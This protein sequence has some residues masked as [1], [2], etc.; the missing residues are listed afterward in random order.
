MEE[1]NDQWCLIRGNFAG[2]MYAK[3][4][5]YYVRQQC[6][7]FIKQGYDIITSECEQSLAAISA[8][9]D[10]LV[11]VTLN[12]DIAAKTHMIDLSQLPNTLVRS[13]IHA[14]RTSAEENLSDAIDSVALN[15]TTLI[16]NMPAQSITTV[17]IPI[18]GTLSSKQ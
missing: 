11:I 12:E 18:I 8:N 13:S 1:N 10:T 15:G 17:L 6:S 2:Q 4:K 5:N 14:Y 16:L 9:R 7:R 3:V